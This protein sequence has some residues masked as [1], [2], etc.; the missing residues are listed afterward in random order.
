MRLMDVGMAPV[1]ALRLSYTGELGYELHHPLEYQ[2]Y[3]YGMICEAGVKYRS[4]DFG[5][6]AL[7]SLRLEMGYR[8]WGTDISARCS[9]FEAGLER[10][11]QLDKGDFLLRAALQHRLASGAAST[12]VAL[13]LDSSA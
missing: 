4:V 2:T 3:L 6:Y 1:R 13:I 9:P 8:S 5:Y 7:E 12:P 11:V 10:F